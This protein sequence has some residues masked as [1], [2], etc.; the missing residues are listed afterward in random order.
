MMSAQAEA[1][2]DSPLVSLS[3]ESPL[4]DISEMSACKKPRIEWADAFDDSL[5]LL[6]GWFRQVVHSFLGFLQ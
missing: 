3:W 4:V 5:P 1:L 2:T 6:F